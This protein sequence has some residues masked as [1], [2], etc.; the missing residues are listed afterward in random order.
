M[1]K[2][3]TVWIVAILALGAVGLWTFLNHYD[4]AIP[5]ASLDFKLSRDEAFLEA[6][7]FAVA[8]D[9]DLLAFENAQIFAP[10]MM[11]QIFLQKSLGLEETNRLARDWISLYRW[12]VRWYR[13]LEKEEVH[14]HLD[15][16]G[17]VVGYDHRILDED[18]GA[19]LS[20][21]E[22]LEIAEAFVFSDGRFAKDAWEEVERSSEARTDR[23]D[24]TFTYRKK[25][26]TV[27]DDG[28]Y[29]VRVVVQGDRV[30]KFREFVFVPETF[31]RGYQETRSRANLL[32]QVFMVLWLAL[33]VS[34]LVI[35]ARRYRAG[36]LQ[37]R[38]STILGI[39]V[40]IA[41]MLAQLNSIPLIAYGYDT[42][43]STASFYL[44]IVMMVTMASLFTGAIVSMTGTAGAWVTRDVFGSS[45]LF[46]RL[47]FRNLLSGRYVRATL[48]GY[49]FAGLML[50]FLI[51]FYY[52]GTEL[53][54]VWSPAY[55]IEYDNAFSTAFPWAYPLLIGLVAAAQE[56][57]FFRLLAIPLLLKW[58][59]I[60][61]L[62]VLVPAIVWGFLHSNY[63]VEPIYSRGVELTIV[64]VGF[65]IVFLKWGIW[66]TIVAHYAY[67]AFVT[68]FPM[69]RSSSLYFQISGVFVIGL[70]C[71]PVIVAAISTIRGRSGSWK[72]DQE[73]EDQ[74]QAPDSEAVAGPTTS[75][76]EGMP[77]VVSLD[78]YVM[79]RRHR[80]I[81]IVSIVVGAALHYGL[82]IPRFGKNSY[83]VNVDRTMAVAR[84]DSVMG[85]LGWSL[86]D[87]LLD[88]T[89]VDRVGSDHFAYLVR[90]VGV[91]KADSLVAAHLHLRDWRVRRFKPQVK[92]EYRVGISPS[93]SL[94]TFERILPDSL[95]GA[96]LESDEARS[97]AAVALKEHFDIDVTDRAVFKVIQSR[98][99]KK[100]NRTDHHF[101]WERLGPKV[102]ESEF[103][104]NATIQGDT[105]GKASFTFKAPEAFLREMREKGTKDAVVQVVHVVSVVALL[106]CA[107]TFFFRFYREGRIGWRVPLFIGGVFGATRVVESINHWPVFYHG[108]DTSQSLG[109]FLGGKAVGLLTS[110]TLGTAVFALFAALALALWRD[111]VPRHP[112]LPTAWRQFR[113]GGG[114]GFF[115]LDAFLG[116]V[117]FSLISRSNGMVLVYIKHHYFPQYETTSSYSL[118]WILGLSPA[119]GG[120]NQI[121]SGLPLFLMILA[122][123]LVVKRVVGEWKW[124]LVI[125]VLVAC[126]QQVG[127]AKDL[128]HGFV[129]VGLTA[130]S[131]A[132]VMCYVVKILRFNLVAY[133]IGVVFVAR[134]TSC[135]RLMQTDMLWYDVNGLIVSVLALIPFWAGLYYAVK[136]RTAG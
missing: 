107:V 82:E 8:C 15:P 4:R 74:V 9:H 122:V 11:S 83:E 73:E 104:V 75:E 129:S 72:E 89:Y 47:S 2:R 1:E 26:F 45:D 86:E 42:M 46:P 96:N 76:P 130:A 99:D 5:V 48:I 13:P 6:Q 100:E 108:F 64:G 62:A 78:S 113:D 85:S 66:S 65:G 121:I 25:G 36:G 84:A 133:F 59:K 17:R 40:L 88:M 31:K 91:P 120:I 111:Q 79:S 16:G 22:A 49:G 127:M 98:A 71:L 115:L 37:W 114:R 134:V 124:A 54:G 116:T 103:R 136:S 132:I 87:A 118:P 3:D 24:H 125:A 53:F 112:D 20:E 55:V 14:V 77:D 128:T 81:T 52:V 110:Y 67:N 27:G 58:F 68:A 12:Q 60:R 94:A 10:D 95:S 63:P 106:V 19:N 29:R 93:G 30:G 61:W 38:S 33:G 131:G 70:L 80:T 23:T 44:T 117:A 102:G 51:L 43:Q 101:V 7:D 69:L 105:I 90:K 123:V 39:G 21:S 41:M 18:P 109:T 32:T 50:G 135:V 119:V 34:V 126:L 28:H 35:L 97:T 57:F 56:E 92:T